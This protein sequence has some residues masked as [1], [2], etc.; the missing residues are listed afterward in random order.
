MPIL[1]TGNVERVILLP[2]AD[3]AT[4]AGV[5]DGADALRKVLKTLN[6]HPIDVRIARIP[7]DGSLGTKAGFDDYRAAMLEHEEENILTA[8][9]EE[10]IENGE[11]PT[12]PGYPEG[13]S[14][15]WDEGR[16]VEAWTEYN[17]ATGKSTSTV[18][19]V[20]EAAIRVAQKVQDVDDLA[21]EGHARHRS[22]E[23]LHLEAVRHDERGEV[24]FGGTTTTYRDM[25]E[26]R[27]PV[28]GLLDRL[29]APGDSFTGVGR[30][31]GGKAPFS[32]IQDQVRDCILAD[33]DSHSVTQLA[34]TGIATLGGRLRWVSESGSML[35][36]GTVDPS[37]FTHYPDGAMRQ[38][39][40]RPIDDL[41]TNELSYAYSQVL[42][43]VL[44][45]AKPGGAFEVA[46]LALLGATAWSMSGAAPGAAL[47][48]IAP[49]GT[50]KTALMQWLLAATRDEKQ[51]LGNLLKFSGTPNWIADAGDGVH[52]FPLLL[53]DL[54]ES[55]ANSSPLTVK[56]ALALARVGLEGPA[57]RKNRKQGARAGFAQATRSQTHP[58]PVM[59]IEPGVI[60][61]GGSTEFYS[62]LDRVLTVVE[63]GVSTSGGRQYLLA[64]PA[65]DEYPIMRDS[66][67]IVI[68]DIARLHLRSIEDLAAKENLDA[69]SA[70]H[71]YAER[72]G[73]KENSARYR[74]SEALGAAGTTRQ[75]SC[76]LTFL[77][78]FEMILDR[79]L[80]VKAIDQ[81]E[82]D[83][84]LSQAESLVMAAVRAHDRRYISSVVPAW[85]QVVR[86]LHDLASG[87]QVWI[88]GSGRQHG[89]GL[90]V[91]R[92]IQAKDEKTG[93]QVDAVAIV[94]ALALSKLEGFGI[95]VTESAA[96]ASFKSISLHPAKPRG[97]ARIP[98]IGD[99]GR[100]TPTRCWIIP[101]KVWDNPE[102]YL[103]G[104]DEDD[105]PTI[106]RVVRHL[107]VVTGDAA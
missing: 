81:E 43:S 2:D 92:R 71:L 7:D 61:E 58:L 63:D 35:S 24:I 57:E 107:G 75:K 74:R 93:A 89:L 39:S 73:S 32:R 86:G 50:G 55:D 78:G 8:L 99:S 95:K 60:P 82:Y 16:I 11:M 84:W 25:V 48:M 51:D 83:W 9:V 30:R 41:S 56:A 59:S 100:S 77:M 68:A 6:G 12:R 27:N 96:D 22:R 54:K 49:S 87:E 20:L 70:A 3:V 90:A 21:P 44:R 47:L 33:S 45:L 52:H 37:V 10:A 104:V 46:P 66:G 103:P 94:P 76:A 4:N 14:V 97:R 5:W 67:R 28:L 98:V 69:K 15:Q 62:Y 42:A 65:E 85:A 19:V 13:I 29:A 1:I 40:L 72:L 34:R 23:T 64:A 79:A 26:S 106:G 53:D 102:D 17:D 91:G 101:A 31:T 36:D 80:E 88:H 38:V 18:E 105:T